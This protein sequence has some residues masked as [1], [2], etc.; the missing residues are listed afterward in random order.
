MK[1][2]SMATQWHQGQF[3]DEGCPYII[4][5]IRASIIFLEETK[6]KNVDITCAIL[7]HDVVEDTSMAIKTLQQQFGKEVARL[8]KA[9]TRKTP[10]QATQLQKNRGKLAKI[11]KIA[12][13]DRNVRLVKLCDQ[14][15]NRRS[16]QFIPIKNASR[17]KFS[18]WDK[19]FAKYLPIAKKT[20][21]NLF[22]L[23]SEY[24]LSN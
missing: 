11:D 13:S 12:R 5:P 17:K 19:E 4:H 3:R 8:V 24:Q 20:N 7:L 18:R 2:L 15:D 23:F 16:R 6:I 21:K 9:V 10:P 14:L 22:A 1:A